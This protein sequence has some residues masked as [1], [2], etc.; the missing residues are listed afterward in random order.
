[1]QL[2]KTSCY[3]TEC[4]TFYSKKSNYIFTWT[5][6]AWI[7][8]HQHVKYVTGLFSFVLLWIFYICS[9]EH[10]YFVIKNKNDKPYHEWENLSDG[11]MKNF[12]RGNGRSGD[13]SPWNETG[14]DGCGL[15]A[16][17]G[18]G[19]CPP[20]RATLP[21]WPHPA[22]GPMRFLSRSESYLTLY[23]L[24]VMKAQYLMEMLHVFEWNG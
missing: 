24:L 18:C 19:Q 3:K 5:E 16:S 7:S 12:I 22:S 10:A 14:S 21:D 1:M 8:I 6:K 9:K 15:G 17:L 4:T 11:H 23:H 13:Y 20:Q 2:S